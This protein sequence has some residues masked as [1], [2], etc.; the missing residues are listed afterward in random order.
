MAVGTISGAFVGA[1]GEDACEVLS[2]EPSTLVLTCG[3][4]HP[5]PSSLI[6]LSVSPGSLRARAVPQMHRQ[7]K[8][9]TGWAFGAGSCLAQSIVTQ[10]APAGLWRP[11][12]C[13]VR[14]VHSQ[15]TRAGPAGV[16]KYCSCCFFFFLIKMEVENPILLQTGS[17]RAPST[18]LL[19]NG[20]Q[21]ED[22]QQEPA[23]LG[24]VCFGCCWVW[25]LR[26]EKGASLIG[27]RNRLSG[28]KA[29][30]RL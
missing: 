17:P 26:W 6:S 1:K 8:L 21:I 25:C 13:F 10:T 18:V 24:S 3:C 29:K 4:H 9:Q 11:S 22:S 15:I 14:C 16:T 30:R 12:I 7:L 20:P 2:S 27:K 19:G 5:G 23:C 28:V